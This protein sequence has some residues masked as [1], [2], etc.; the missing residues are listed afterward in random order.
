MEVPL[1]LRQVLPVAALVVVA[2]ASG[3]SSSS[4]DSAPPLPQNADFDTPMQA[5]MKPGAFKANQHF[6]NTVDVQ[7]GQIVVP[8]DDANQQTLSKIQVG[9]VIAGNRDTATAD[10]TMS[11][12]PYG[13]LRKVDAITPGDNGTVILTTE[14]AAIDDWMDEGDIL[15]GAGVPSMFDDIDPSAPAPQSVH[16]LGGSSSGS[17]PSTSSE[18][19]SIEGDAI[20]DATKKLTVRPFASISNVSFALNPKL[21]GDL[22]I[23]K[24]FWVPT[25]IKEAKLVLTMDPAVSADLEVGVRV[26]G[27]GTAIGGPNGYPLASMSKSW[28]G[29]SIV[30]PLD[31]GIPVTVR[32]EPQLQCTISLQGSTSVKFRAELK[33]HAAAGFDY[34]GSLH[35]LSVPPTFDPNFLHWVSGKVEL[36]G[37]AECD[38]LMV[39]AVLAFDAIGLQGKVGPYV[40]LNAQAC[41]VYD[42][43]TSTTTEGLAAYEQHGLVGEFGA[44]VQVP[45]FSWGKSFD[46]V[47]WH[48]LKSN[49]FYFLGSSK[50]CSVHSADSCAGKAD[51]FYCSQLASYSGFYCE[52]GSLVEGLQ[53]DDPTQKCKS[54]T[55]T[56]ITCQ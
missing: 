3:C 27:G 14:Q 48:G 55:K 20:T 41:V 8:N 39:P 47:T 19:G 36:D 43:T 54:G 5:K 10:L 2:I 49:P 24:T 13:F 1:K 53:C 9:S 32:F 34:D 29:K 30:I 16:I 26:T 12:N 46:L 51:G 35:D 33:M 18:A 23:R 44:R 25:G 31:A 37:S 52:G 56:S 11:K 4:S 22:K 38:L 50:T 28:S 45:I 15:I 40:A 21:D 6:A 7:D 42:A 17:T